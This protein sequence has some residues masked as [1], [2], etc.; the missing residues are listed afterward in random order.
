MYDD[1]LKWIK[2]SSASWA[3]DG[4]GFYYSRYEAPEGTDPY[5]EQNQFNK[6]Y[7]HKIGTDQSTDQIDFGSGLVVEPRYTSN[8]GIIQ[9]T[10][11]LPNVI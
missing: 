5:K 9:P 2:F 3:P 4:S 10:P 6:L 8:H 11:A 7:F 1:H